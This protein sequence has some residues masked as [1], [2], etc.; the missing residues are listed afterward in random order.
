VGEAEIAEAVR[1]CGR[2]PRVECLVLAGSLMGGDISRAVREI[3]ALGIVVVCLKMAGSVGKAADLVVSDPI[4]AGV[5]AVMLV[6]STAK[7][8][9]G[10]VRGKEF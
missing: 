4:Q 5:M 7:L 8:D 2:L 9:I 10:R 3:Q 1:A 6:A